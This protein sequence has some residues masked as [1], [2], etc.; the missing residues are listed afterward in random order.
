MEPKITNC[1]DE[2]ITQTF[3]YYFIYSGATKVFRENKFD[4]FCS[5]GMYHFKGL[6]EWALKKFK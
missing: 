2:T 5:I 1:K 6:L 4:L 3:I